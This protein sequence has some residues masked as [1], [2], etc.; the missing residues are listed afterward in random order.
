MDLPETKYAKNGDLHIAYSVLG[1]GPVDLVLCIGWV[2]HIEQL[3]EDP[4]AERFLRRCASFARVIVF[5]KRGVGLSDRPSGVP[6]LE[7]RMDDICAVMDAASSRR[8][9]VFG[10]S[11]GAPTAILL[12]ATYPERVE[13]L[14][15]FGGYA[16]ATRDENHP[17]GLDLAEFEARISEVVAAWG[18]DKFVSI[19]APSRR[20][21]GAFRTWWSR[22]LRSAA[23]PGGVNS[24]MRLYPRIDVRHILSAIRV[25]T[26]VV[27]R[28][29]DRLAPV[30]GGRYLAQH[31]PGA[32]Y[33]ELP[34]TDHWPF[35]GD[36]DAVVGEVEEF[37]TGGRSVEEPDRVLATVLFTDIVDSTH[38]AVTVGDQRWRELLEESERVT[39]R[40]V[41][42]HRGRVVK[43]TG[44]GFLATFD[45]PARAI[46]CA[47]N[48]SAEMMKLGLRIRAGLH[49]GECEMLGDDVTGIAVHIG[50][51]VAALASRDEVLVSSTVKDLVAGSGLSFDDR[52]THALKGVPGSWQIFAVAPT[53]AAHVRP[54]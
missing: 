22:Y 34:G 1:D 53:R 51:R 42:R 49:T 29:D 18:T 39:R 19:W 10:I 8:A 5:D 27:H 28:T 11:E 13:A 54:Q 15:L 32:R 12:A 36:T 3:W 52:G 9:A 30:E 6:T 20:R 44:D 41:E 31:I 23:S 40:E 17:W 16:F 43:S 45:G 50:A 7:D 33:L 2:T 21:D 4:G 48:L 37:L 35:S 25:P 47:T 14:V 46:R 26:L 38:K 24:L